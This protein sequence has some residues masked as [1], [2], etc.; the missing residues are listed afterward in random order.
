MD[1]LQQHCDPSDQNCR[2][3]R[4]LV[5]IINLATPT[6][7]EQSQIN[8]NTVPSSWVCGDAIAE[9]LT[10][11]YA[12]MLD[13]PPDGEEL[14][15]LVWTA[16]DVGGVYGNPSVS[17]DA[18]HLAIAALVVEGVASDIATA[19]WDG[20]I[21]RAIVELTGGDGS[22]RVVVQQ[23]DLRKPVSKSTLYKFHGC[24][25]LA[26]ADPNHYR[27][28]IVGRASQ[29]TGFAALNQNAAVKNR[30]TDIATTKPT[31]MMGMSAQ[32]ANIQGVFA[33]A[34]ANMTWPWPNDPP[35]CVFAEDALGA[36]QVGLLRHVYNTS[37]TTVT[38]GEI[39][40]SALLRVFG[41]TL[42]PA[43]WC[44]VLRRKLNELVKRNV[45][46]PAQE[47]A[48]LEVGLRELRDRAAAACLP[49]QQEAFVRQALRFAR[50][51]LSLFRRGEE[52]P[53]SGPLYEALTSSESAGIA[54]DP[55]I[56]N[57]GLP[58]LAIGIG[59]FGLHARSGTWNVRVP[60][61][62]SAKPGSLRV[63]TSATSADV[64]FAANAEV[65]ITMF[66][67]GILADSDPVVLVHSHSIPARFTRSPRVSPGRVGTPR[68]KE[69]SITA[70]LEETQ[71]VS[72]A[73]ARLRE[74]L[75][76]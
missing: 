45:S 39:R 49:N 61:P 25:V 12:R 41:R 65:A 64:F 57:S 76:L 21:E 60:D 29:I 59:M 18:E 72:V 56:P 70:L 26:R 48:L 10:L 13:M 1:H 69:V 43:L 38:A 14:D 15:Y 51:A 44:E 46:L 8:Y 16:L 52:P 42:L 50:R 73:L 17:P 47:Q 11:N 28:H 40:A 31:L 4:S 75:A 3:R 6:A 68:L 35:A 30:L 58:E 2:F 36:D 33:Q 23:A 74:E 55:S 71:I 53:A 24:A 37:Y 63:A 27:E 19:N 34:S 22:L 7:S 62:A 20:L 54:T 5:S 66:R 67:D 32:D 9:R